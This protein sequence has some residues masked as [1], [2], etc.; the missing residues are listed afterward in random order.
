[1]DVESAIE[2]E[3]GVKPS[4]ETRISLAAMRHWGR[5]EWE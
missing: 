3:K 2:R 5:G 4:S 1:V